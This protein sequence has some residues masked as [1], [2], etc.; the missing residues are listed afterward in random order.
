[1]LRMLYWLPKAF[2]GSSKMLA[3]LCSDLCSDAASADWLL[4]LDALAWRPEEKMSSL[5]RK[6]ERC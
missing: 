2:R 5:K 4:G 6:K 1:M 3:T